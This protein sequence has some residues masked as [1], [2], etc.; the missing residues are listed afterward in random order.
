MTDDN[1]ARKPE[2]RLGKPGLGRINRSKRTMNH[3]P[4]DTLIHERARLAI[5]SA[6]A[7]NDSLSFTELKELLNLTDG[8]LSVHAQKLESAG[9]VRCKKTFNGRKPRTEY[10]LTATG[11]RTL[12]KYL[13]HM[14]SLI[15][16]VRSPQS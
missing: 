2:A 9:Y 11:R 10:R 1:T 15:N 4:L 12:E 13:N 14:E 7:V 5:V 6:L 8:N 3:D 16:A